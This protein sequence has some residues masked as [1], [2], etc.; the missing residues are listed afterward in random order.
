MCIMC[1]EGATLDEVRFNIHAIIDRYGWFIQYVEAFPTSRAWAY[2][3]GVTAGW[4]HPELVVAG[5]T[6]QAAARV[7]NTLGEMIR[8]GQSFTPDDSVFV[9]SSGQVRFSEVHAAHYDQGL[10]AAWVDYY[11]CLGTQLPATALEVLLPG[12]E[13]QLATPSSSIGH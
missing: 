7:L 11:E 1:D 8:E 2:T 4:D 9:P 13:A 5:V 10:L 12:R 6:P 3:I